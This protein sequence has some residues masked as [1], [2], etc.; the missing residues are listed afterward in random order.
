MAA[1][2]TFWN[3][4]NLLYSVVSFSFQHAAMLCCPS[5]LLCRFQQLDYFN[6]TKMV[7]MKDLTIDEAA[8]IRWAL[9]LAR[10]EKFQNIIEQFRL[11]RI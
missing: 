1:V 6:R 4:M 9:E 10:L 2:R 3:C 5:M 11:Q 8:A 7:E